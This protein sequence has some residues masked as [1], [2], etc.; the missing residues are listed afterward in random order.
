MTS[1]TTKSIDWSAIASELSG[2]EVI[3]DATQITKLSLDYYHFSPV[4]QP[5]LRD[6]RGD[7][8]VRPISEAE[9]L[10]VAQV[11]VKHQVP[12]TVRGAG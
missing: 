2:M 8:V 3:T 7:L 6:K 4:L 11:C 5:Q 9:V 12:L 10:R 1:T